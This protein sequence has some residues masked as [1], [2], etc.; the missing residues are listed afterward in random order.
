MA[1]FFIIEGPSYFV[2][3]PQVHSTW[4]EGVPERFIVS[5]KLID[6]NETEELSEQIDHK[7]LTLNKQGFIKNPKAALFKNF[8]LW[9]CEK[10]GL[11]RNH[12]ILIKN[13]RIE[14]IGKTFR[15]IQQ[16]GPK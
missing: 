8:H 14:A 11:L 12:D 13:G 1:N 5:Q 2:A 6:K 7:K 16:K 15:L 4:I 3:S 9:T 10:E